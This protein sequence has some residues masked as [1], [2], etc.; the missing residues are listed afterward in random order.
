MVD[1][2]SGGAGPA[3]ISTVE[4]LAALAAGSQQATDLV[5]RFLAEL[6]PVEAACLA[7]DW[8]FF[9]RPKQ[10][11]PPG[12]WRT[13]GHI[14]GRG[15]GKTIS[16][17]QFVVDEMTSGR[18]MRV[19]LIAQTADKAEEV[20]VLGES[21]LVALSP[22][23]CK[24]SYERGRV[25]MPNGAQAFIYTPERPKDIFGPEHHLAWATELHAWPASTMELA[26]ANLRMGVRLGYGRIV[27]DTNPAKRNPIIVELLE[28][29]RHD[30]ASYPVVI[31][32]AVEN[33]HNMTR[34]EV[35]RWIR[36]YGHTARGRAMIYGIQS[37]DDDGALW[38]QAWIDAHRRPAP[39]TLRRRVLT[40]DPA[41]SSRAGTDATGISDV[42][43]GLDD[44]VFV[45]ADL[46]AHLKW[47]TWGELV[48]KRYL[49]QRCDCI[50]IERNRGGDACVANIRACAAKIA[51]ATGTTLDVVV[52]AADAKTR[53]VPGTIYV[54]EVIGRQSKGTRAEP[55]ASHYEAGRVSHVE[56]ATLRDLED[57]LT[58]WVPDEKGESP[59]A[60]DA[61]VYGVVEVAG[62][63]RESVPDGGA[64]IQAAV[65]MQEIVKAAPRQ[66]SGNI[67]VLLGGG[68]GR[69]RI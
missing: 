45:F 10:T 49:A 11:P 41:I 69:E 64:A 44:Q 35:D 21:G 53:H 5:A 63:T 58:T 50:V 46:S 23:W 28:E 31:H 7:Y 27:W 4:Q 67:A 17:G 18:A 65:K 36:K 61:L 42:G 26:W 9:R 51:A 19:A 22:P 52:V 55:V 1:L 32:S 40:C 43:L 8:T 15:A 33:K 48:V 37:D 16:N 24:A 30:P 59:N 68:R 47:E 12:D 57:L 25:V 60:L 20:L 38:Q 3:G 2:G 62:L 56:G 54:K 13:W 34:G 29:F 14:G 66:G 39:E 6:D